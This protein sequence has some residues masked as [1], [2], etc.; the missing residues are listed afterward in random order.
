MP[1]SSDPRTLMDARSQR[2][3]N[4]TSEDEED[5]NSDDELTK[6]L[7]AGF[8]ND[9][10]ED[11]EVGT[12]TSNTHDLLNSPTASAFET[13]SGIQAP[14]TST[15]QSI[16]ESAVDLEDSSE[17]GE[18]EDIFPVVSSSAATT[19][20]PADNPSQVLSSNSPKE[21]LDASPTEERPIV[22]KGQKNRPPK[23]TKTSHNYHGLPRRYAEDGAEIGYR[24]AA[25][26]AHTYA[27]VSDEP[28][29]S[30]D[31]YHA[32]G[33][34]RRM[35]FESDPVPKHQQYE[36]QNARLPRKPGEI[37]YPDAADKMYDW[38]RTRR[39]VSGATKETLED[40]KLPRHFVLKMGLPHGP[41]GEAT[42]IAE[43]L[44]SVVNHFFYNRL[45][46]S[47]LTIQIEIP[48]HFIAGGG[49]FKAYMD[50]I[51]VLMNPHP[52]ATKK[53][54]QRLTI[55]L[56]KRSAQL[57]RNCDPRSF[58]PKPFD[59][60]AEW[61]N[62]VGNNQHV[63]TET[64]PGT[65]LHMPDG[66]RPTQEQFE[67]A[68]KAY[69]A[70]GQIANLHKPAQVDT[71]I[72]DIKVFIEEVEQFQHPATSAVP[73]TRLPGTQT[74]GASFPQVSLNGLN[75][76]NAHGFHDDAQLQQIVRAPSTP[77]TS[78]M[79]STEM[80]QAPSQ[81]Q[82]PQNGP[83]YG[84]Q[85]QRQQTQ[86]T[87]VSA[88]AL[89]NHS[90]IADAPWGNAPLPQMGS[91]R[92]PLPHSIP[93]VPHPVPQYPE[94]AHGWQQTARSMSIV[95]PGTRPQHASTAQ[96][97]PAA[98]PAQSL[99]WSGGVSTV[100]TQDPRHLNRINHDSSAMSFGTPQ[101]IAHQ[102]VQQYQYQYQYHHYPQ[103]LRESPA[104]SLPTSTY[105][106]T[107]MSPPLPTL[108]PIATNT[109]ARTA[110]MNRKRKDDE[111]AA[112]EHLNKRSRK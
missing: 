105:G 61:R 108:E 28:I 103:N 80:A 112:G 33:C 74:D 65:Q 96:A 59:Y 21:Q 49:Y 6:E 1:Y 52:N 92:Q 62:R 84:F 15:D 2:E 102:E 86:H 40:G 12:R 73:T 8:E 79:P 85:E 34:Q 101:F 81:Q 4:A 110:S 50:A 30:D 53:L 100:V 76:Q 104:A 7:M 14:L 29:L 77:A 57:F 16:A 9:S 72:A 17:E 38:C 43:R 39:G 83:H 20:V 48:F 91:F 87:F 46:K 35:V 47:H 99:Q 22:S 97:G 95:Q 93:S 107:F 3:G 5:S 37:D 89:Q 41:N 25:P 94:P 78:R 58:H 106:R 18:F 51:R 67:A 10:D 55:E 27:Y 90:H 11:E 36:S 64:Y 45:V 19:A 44:K 60:E 42:R 70:R 69:L 26:G 23:G 109:E 71:A 24:E 13:S 54:G 98:L 66:W 75:Q 88:Q 68:K 31:P 56:D 82:H 32:K 111:D 63:F